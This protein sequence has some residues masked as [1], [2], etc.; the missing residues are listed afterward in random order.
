MLSPHL[1]GQRIRRSRG[2]P[3]LTITKQSCAASIESA[4]DCELTKLT[5]GNSLL[6]LS[7]GTLR[8]IGVILIVG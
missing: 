6:G 7:L 1:H 8:F 5:S 4:S 2:I 3:R